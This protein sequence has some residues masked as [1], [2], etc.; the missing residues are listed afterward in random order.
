[1]LYQDLRLGFMPRISSCLSGTS[2]G[3]HAI[4]HIP[5]MTSAN[6]PMPTIISLPVTMA[7]QK[8][9]KKR[10]RQTM[11]VMPAQAGRWPQS[12]WCGCSHVFLT[13]RRPPAFPGSDVA[14]AAGVDAA[15][16]AVV[17]Q[18]GISPRDRASHE[19]LLQGS[20]YPHGG[21]PPTRRGTHA[22]SADDQYAPRC[23]RKHQRCSDPLHRGVLFLRPDVHLLRRRLPCRGNGQGVDPVRQAQSRLRRCLQYHG[24][25]RH[26]AH[27]LG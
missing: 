11:I 2:A 25:H 9:I 12:R 24:T 21:R 6:A 26:P 19:Q 4:A 23:A 1:M 8:S 13:R 5:A 3:Q 22:S 20:R 10:T 15:E 7:N 17:V 18:S 14:P 27:R 16:A